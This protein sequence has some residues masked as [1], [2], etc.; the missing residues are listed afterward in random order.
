MYMLN[1]N[2]MTCFILLWNY[3]MC[4]SLKVTPARTN[5][6][7]FGGPDRLQ[8]TIWL[9]GCGTWPL[10]LHGL[11]W[12]PIP[13][14]WPINMELIPLPPWPLIWSFP[15]CG[16]NILYSSVKAFHKMQRVSVWICTMCEVRY[17]CWR[18]RPASQ[19]FFRSSPPTSVLDLNPTEHQRQA[20]SSP[21]TSIPN[22]F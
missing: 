13:K 22:H 19:L 17:W 6:S 15:L 18:W 12:D 4:Y 10:H 21:P 1:A 14:P 11:V 3:A 2:W 9:K 8:Y 5:I 16:Y 7:G 20:R